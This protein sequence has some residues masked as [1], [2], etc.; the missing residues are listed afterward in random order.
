MKMVIINKAFYPTF[1]FVNGETLYC[2]IILS[3]LYYISKLA[4]ALR[5][6]DLGGRALL[7]GPVK[8]KVV[9]VT[10][11]F[12]DLSPIFFKRI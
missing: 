2:T 5:L 1:H 12:R 3:F 4:L 11:M 10:K 9:S 6:V 7:H 8:F